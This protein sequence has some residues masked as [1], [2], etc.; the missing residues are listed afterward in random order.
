[1][2]T[3]VSMLMPTTVGICALPQQVPENKVLLRS[4]FF[5][6]GLLCHTSVAF[7]TGVHQG[8]HP[9]AV[10]QL[11]RDPLNLQEVL[12]PVHV[13]VVHALEDWMV[14]Y[15]ILPFGRLWRTACLRNLNHGRVLYLKGVCCWEKMKQVT[16]VPGSKMWWNVLGQP[17]H[18]T[19][20]N[21]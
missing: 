1:M 4:F 3:R 9:S 13:A 8:G 11:D 12:Q 20:G 17:G 5:F 18:A 15:N 6:G 21:P 10:Q 14:V 2:Q 7:P 19:L 16:G